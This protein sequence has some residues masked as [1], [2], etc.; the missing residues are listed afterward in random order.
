M[1]HVLRTAVPLIGGKN[2]TNEMGVLM[3]L[4]KSYTWSWVVSSAECKDGSVEGS[5]SSVHLECLETFLFVAP[6]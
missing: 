4:G 1:I 2:Y 6:E 3:T 5:P